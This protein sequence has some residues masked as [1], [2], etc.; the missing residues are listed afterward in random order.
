MRSRERIKEKAHCQHPVSFL[1]GLVSMY[2]QGWPAVLP[3]LA[4]DVIAALLGLT[5]DEN[6]A[7]IHLPLQKPHKALILG[8]LR[9]KLEVL[10]YAF[11]CI[12]CCGADCDLHARGPWTN[13]VTKTSDF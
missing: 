6:P 11:V 1:L 9:H 7:A 10:L 13:V 4:G 5:E 12:Q 3:E 8:S 2:G